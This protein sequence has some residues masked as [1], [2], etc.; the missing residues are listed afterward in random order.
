MKK[1]TFALCALSAFATQ[2]ME[3][4]PVSI[5]ALSKIIESK[6]ANERV[7][8]PTQMEIENGKLVSKHPVKNAKKTQQPL[9]GPSQ[10]KNAL[11]YSTKPTL[12]PRAIVGGSIVISTVANPT[13]SNSGSANAP[14]RD[15]KQED[16]DS[17]L[18]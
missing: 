8:K 2:A 4:A 1:I 11:L 12:T 7:L 5:E 6:F 15:G 16:T 9:V 3:E 18:D 17:S 14:A 13:T 10:S